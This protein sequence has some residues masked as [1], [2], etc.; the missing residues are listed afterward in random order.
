[1]LEYM[2]KPK[3][4][5]IPKPIVDQLEAL[6]E[7]LKGLR[8][9]P[10]YTEDN[11]TE[12]SSDDPPELFIDDDVRDY[13]ITFLIRHDVMLLL[14]EIYEKSRHYGSPCLYQEELD[15]GPS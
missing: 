14:E 12:A 9:K 11:P 1:M 2:A 13:V 8:K 4:K 10:D 7:I 15:Q 5:P 3:S 6:V